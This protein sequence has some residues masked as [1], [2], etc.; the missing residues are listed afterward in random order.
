MDDYQIIFITYYC[1]QK[2]FERMCEEKNLLIS[3]VEPSEDFTENILF[4]KAKLP[5]NLLKYWNDKDIDDNNDFNNKSFDNLYALEEICDINR[6][7]SIIKT[8]SERL[9]IYGYIIHLDPEKRKQIAFGAKE[10]WWYIYHTNIDI[11]REFYGEYN[12]YYIAWLQHLTKWL[13]YLSIFSLVGVIWQISIASTDTFFSSVYSFIV[14]IW[15]TLMLN[16][17][18]LFNHK[19]NYIWNHHNFEISE[20]LRPEFY[21]GDHKEIDYLGKTIKIKEKQ[22]T[23]LT[24]LKTYSIYSFFLGL[25]V[26]N[27]YLSHYIK[28]ILPYTYGELVSC[29]VST[30]IMFIIESIFKKTIKRLNDIENHAT[31]TG[32][33]DGL[34]IKNV[35]FNFINT[36]YNIY[37]SILYEPNISISIYLFF[38]YFFKEIIIRHFK[39]FVFS[40]CDYNQQ[41]I[42]YETEFEKIHNEY[43]ESCVEIDTIQ[44]HSELV[45]LF[46]YMTMF[47]CFFPGAC[48]LF[49][50]NNHYEMIKDLRSFEKSKLSLPK[51]SGGIGLWKDIYRYTLY[52]SIISNS[53]FLLFYSPSFPKFG[54]FSKIIL[55]IAFEHFII[56]LGI[57]INF[58]WPTVPNKLKILLKDDYQLKQS[59]KNQKKLDSYRNT[60][61]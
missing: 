60:I 50:A 29:G 13:F 14:P 40:F 20:T 57:I 16:K 6:S 37:Y 18:D 1:D 3:F 49:L 52:L 9:H 58:F 28:N 32:Y 30:I 24:Y 11:I 5:D 19:R 51:K 59:K 35:I 46:S 25:I 26:A 34:V 56:G 54:G 12:A 8:E 7:L 22:N 10:N 55:I 48:L 2:N 61:V 38:Q 21:S 44:E 17:W 42:E 47:A 23:I 41:S 36:F 27:S 33:N 15:S 31:E 43:L 53:F 4:Y 45:I 39:D